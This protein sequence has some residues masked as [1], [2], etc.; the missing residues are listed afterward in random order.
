MRFVAPDAAFWS[1]PEQVFVSV[2]DRSTSPDA[3]E[4]YVSGLQECYRGFGA[5]HIVEREDLERG[6]C[7]MF[8][9]ITGT[10]GRVVGGARAVGPFL[11]TDNIDDV[12]VVTELSGSPSHGLL[13][14]SLAELLPGGLVEG[15]GAWSAPGV[16]GLGPL[17]GRFLWHCSWWFSA[18]TTVATSG[19]EQNIEKWQ[20]AGGRPIPGVEPAADFPVPDHHTIPLL[21]AAERFDEL[22]MELQNRLHDE[23]SYLHPARN[24]AGGRSGSGIEIVVGEDRLGELRQAGVEVVDR[25][26]ELRDE[27]QRCRSIDPGARGS[28]EAAPWVHYPWRRTAIRVLGPAEF[29]A[30]RTDRNRH[31]L[32]S[33]ELRT[34]R[35]KKV[36]VIGL[37]V[38]NPIAFGLAQEGL[39]GHLRLGDFDTLE[40][41][42]LNRLPGSLLDLGSSKTTIAARRIAELD[43]YLELELFEEGI[44]GTNLDRFLDGLDLVIEECDSLDLKILVRRAAA[45]RGVPV[46]METNDGGLLDVERFDLDPDRPPF[47]GLIGDLDP[48]EV[49][50]LTQ[51]EKVP[52]VLRIIDAERATTDLAASLVEIDRTISS[53]PQLASDVAL[54]TALAVTSARNILLGRSDRS[55]RS[56]VDLDRL[57]ADPVDPLTIQAEPDHRAP[58][59][60]PVL[61]RPPL[62]SGFES[63]MMTAA[64]LAPSGGNMQPWRFVLVEDRFEVYA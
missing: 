50:G 46:V 52:F 9:L 5:G 25:L 27:A 30:V 33:D 42:N 10:D 16:K 22:P 55:G 62:D 43:P 45:E 26:P 37:S 8:W 64:S 39:C 53:W 12:P 31:K 56:R 4:I 24:R 57:L 51:D 59:R 2:L 7:S 54:G 28:D 34:L 19:V 15:K 32:T 61:N 38:G 3:W 63:A 60:P 41:S 47:H 17:F 49:A 36:G 11:G 58:A 6:P 29:H 20:A 1:E 14:S 40:L 13:R 44:D 21:L 18:A 35:R 48:A 23:W